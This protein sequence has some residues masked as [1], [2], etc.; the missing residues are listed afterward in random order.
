MK[1][2]IEEIFLKETLPSLNCELSQKQDLDGE[3]VT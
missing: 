3:R 1:V 2:N